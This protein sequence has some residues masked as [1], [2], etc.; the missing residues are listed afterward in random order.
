MRTPV[1]KRKYVRYCGDIKNIEN[2]SPRTLVNYIHILQREKKI[3]S[4]ENII[5]KRICRNNKKKIASLKLLFAELKENKNISQDTEE[6]L[7]V[8]KTALI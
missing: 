3:K 8:G 5:L 2:S 1:R 6:M 4:K 7:Q